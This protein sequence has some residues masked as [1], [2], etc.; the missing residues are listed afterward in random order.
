MRHRYLRPAAPM[1]C[2]AAALGPDVFLGDR[3][4]H[5]ATVTIRPPPSNSPMTHV[6]SPEPEA[7]GVRGDLRRCATRG[8]NIG[9][10]RLG[11]SIDALQL[12]TVC[13]E[14][15]SRGDARAVTA[16]RVLASDQAHMVSGTSF[17]ATA[18]PA[19]CAASLR[20]HPT[21]R[22]DSC[23]RS[24]VRVSRGKL[25]ASWRRI[26]WCCAQLASQASAATTSAEVPVSS[27]G[28]ITGA[29]FGE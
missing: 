27:V 12:G 21:T 23:P 7:D 14:Q 18:W 26:L 13:S 16:G 4:T 1:R 6:Q 17:A 5:L 15:G 10:T 28:W 20:S 19:L 24:H 22:T 25:A 3:A 8:V 11:V 9:Q 29:K 2:L